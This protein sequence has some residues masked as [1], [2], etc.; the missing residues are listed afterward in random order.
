MRN[1]DRFANNTTFLRIIWKEVNNLTST[2]KKHQGKS[3]RKILPEKKRKK[4]K[5]KVEVGLNSQGK[6]S[7]ATPKGDDLSLVSSPEPK[8]LASPGGKAG[9]NTGKNKKLV[10]LY[11]SEE[12]GVPKPREPRGALGTFAIEAKATMSPLLPR[13]SLREPVTPGP[14]KQ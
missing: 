12:I 5:L 6:A 13:R 9:I 8:S 3:N 14:N 4:D 10:S 11:S 2:F 7:E 1:V